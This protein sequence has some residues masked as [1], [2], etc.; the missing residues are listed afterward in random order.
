MFTS[1][2]DRDAMVL[3][4]TETLF[5]EKTQRLMGAGGHTETQREGDRRRDKEAET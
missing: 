2:C 3:E 5:L 1:S 4:E